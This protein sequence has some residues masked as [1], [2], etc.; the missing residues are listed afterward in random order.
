MKEI[1][2]ISKISFNKNLTRT[3][4]FY[5]DFENKFDKN[6]IFGYNLMEFI[7]F[8]LKKLIYEKN[9][10]KK[11][12]NGIE[13]NY[14]KNKIDKNGK[15]K[16]NEKLKIIEQIID[17]FICLIDENNIY[18]C[19]IKP[20]NILI[21]IKKLNN[22]NKK[23]KLEF[24]ENKIEINSKKNK[25]I[26]IKINEF[27][28]D[29]N[30]EFEL[31]PKICDFG[32]S[33]RKKNLNENQ[34]ENFKLL[35]TP[36]YCSPEL[37]NEYIRNSG[38][39]KYSELTDIYSFGIMLFEI[40]FERFPFDEKE[41]FCL[42]KKDELIFNK[43]LFINDI[44]TNKLK[45]KLTN[46]EKL[47]LKNNEIENKIYNVC[48]VECLNVESNKRPN[49]IQIKNILNQIKGIIIY[50]FIFFFNFFL[51]FFYFFFNFFLIFFFL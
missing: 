40:L 4:G 44:V 46:K 14:L 31:I 51:I 37:L 45:P 24:I 17:G 20:E 28:Y 5:F 25:N 42:N 34:Q 6:N 8:D 22:L 36:I 41:Y 15:I 19:D 35:G 16:I 18:H 26:L 7:D 33:L 39:Y 30:Y 23:L 9:K 13:I 10:F 21:K 47:F 12:E 38:D 27:K 49:F 43:D 32:L 11:I 2:T 50:F 3:F 1:S 29:E 48:V